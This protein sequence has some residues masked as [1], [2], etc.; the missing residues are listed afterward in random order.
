MRNRKRRPLVIRNEGARHPL[1][2]QLPLSFFKVEV[3]EA[4]S[5]AIKSSTSRWFNED[6]SLFF[7]SFVTFFTAFY[8]FIF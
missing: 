6:T 4:D 3:E 1:R 5:A 7:L 8:L 2:Q